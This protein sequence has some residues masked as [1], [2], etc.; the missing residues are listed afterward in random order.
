MIDR[1]FILNE[2]DFII[3]LN[4]WKDR[5]EISLNNYFDKYKDY[6]AYHNVQ[7]MELNCDTRT[8]YYAKDGYHSEIPIT[9]FV[10]HYFD[11]IKVR[12]YTI[13]NIIE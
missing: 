6:L 2:V 13:N 10:N 5:C 4:R 11:P 12:L 9:D 7:V 3:K 8:I 1:Q